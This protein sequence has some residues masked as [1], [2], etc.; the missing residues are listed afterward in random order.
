[1]R[2][3]VLLLAGF[4]VVLP[5]SSP[6]RAQESD[7]E[8]TRL[9][10]QVETRRKELRE[11]E[12]RLNRALRKAEVRSNQLPPLPGG[13]RSPFDLDTDARSKPPT[14]PSRTLPGPTP[15]VA[16]ASTDPNVAQATSDLEDRLAGLERKLDRLI[17]EM[18]EMRREIEGL[19]R[20][21]SR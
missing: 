11:A 9:R 19:K 8:I 3:R 14:V 16:K 1:M 4:L 12:D 6:I 2:T 7:P 21:R 5:Q 18:Q 10:E 20:E 17:E 15:Q 13:G